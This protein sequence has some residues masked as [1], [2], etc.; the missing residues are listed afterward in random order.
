MTVVLA[1]MLVVIP[2]LSMGIYQIWE[3]Q[4]VRRFMNGQ[5]AQAPLA[6]AHTLIFEDELLKAP[7]EV[8]VMGMD[9]IGRAGLNGE[10]KVLAAVKV[11]AFSDAYSFDARVNKAVLK[12]EAFGNTFYQEP[13]DSYYLEVYLYDLG[14]SE[15]DVLSTYNIGNGDMQE[16][17]WF[18]CIPKE[19]QELELTVMAGTGS[20]GHEAFLEGTIPLD[21]VGTAGL[22]D[23]EAE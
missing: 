12:Y 19:A 17:Y 7:V 21:D 14:L 3:A 8:S 18:F 10:D 1:A 4:A 23:G 20:G 6:D 9:I 22:A 11:Q 5:I 15:E 16:G 13:V 2:F